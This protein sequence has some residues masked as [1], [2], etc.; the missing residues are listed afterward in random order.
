MQSAPALMGRDVGRSGDWT[1]IQTPHTT[2]TPMETTR[3]R[4]CPG[5]SPAHAANAASPNNV[6]AW[7]TRAQ[8][9]T[10]PGPGEYMTHVAMQRTPSNTNQNGSASLHQRRAG[11]G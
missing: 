4:E 9:T 2:A 7:N 6:T 3:N 5:A 11:A 10:C 8:G 1:T